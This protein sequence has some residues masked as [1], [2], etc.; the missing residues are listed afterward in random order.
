M[1][2]CRF[3]HGLS[4]DVTNVSVRRMHIGAWTGSQ[5]GMVGYYDPHKSQGPTVIPTPT[6]IQAFR[7]QQLNSLWARF[8]CTSEKNH[9][10]TLETTKRLGKR[11]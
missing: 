4:I 5:G 6:F 2:N 8:L 11:S 3:H 7:T 10:L 1:Q 9:Q